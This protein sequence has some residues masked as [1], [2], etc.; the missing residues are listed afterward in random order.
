MIDIPE[1]LQEPPEGDPAEAE[2]TRSPTEG[3]PVPGRLYVVA[4]PIGN[5]S[6]IGQRA[7]TTLQR[8]RW[9]AAE[10]SRVSRVLLDRLGIS[11]RLIA[12]HEHNERGAAARIVELLRHG[13]AVALITDAG[14]PAISDPGGRVVQAVRAAGFESVPIPGPSAP[15]ALLSVA[16]F[17]PAPFLFE[18]F[19]PTKA[20]QRDTRLS[21]LA[22]ECDALGAHLVLFEAPHRIDK[23]LA[24][25]AQA[26]G[27]TRE[28]VIGRELT[29][30]FEQVH[31]CRTG[32]AVDWLAQRPEHGRGEFVLAVAA[33]ARMRR[34][35]AGEGDGDDAPAAAA[36]RMLPDSE[37]L[38]R[39]LLAELPASRAVKLAQALTGQGHRELYAMALALK[40]G[41]SSAHEGPDPAQGDH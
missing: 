4:T 20:K 6:D 18:G 38:L 17:E 30:K 28:L 2:P 40:G 36:A 14:T 35:D 23:T 5:L 8:V 24:A 39:M 22:R 13:E 1:S 25:I 9:I 29:K 31:R 27:P 3:A 7:V 26:Y 16:G 12:A 34:D 19:L 11:A 37:S 33:P 41:R 21:L 10:D 32:D 15:V